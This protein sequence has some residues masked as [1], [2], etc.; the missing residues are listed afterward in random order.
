M[1]AYD[2]FFFKFGWEPENY[3]AQWKK[4]L[5]PLGATQ[6]VLILPPCLNTAFQCQVA[7][8]TLVLIWEC[9]FEVDVRLAS[10][11]GPGW[12]GQSGGS[13]GVVCGGGW[14]EEGGL[15]EPGTAGGR[16]VGGS[17]GGGG[18]VGRGGGN[19]GRRRVLVVVRRGHAPVLGSPVGC[20]SHCRPYYP[21]AGQTDGH[22]I[23]KAGYR[24][25]GLRSTTGSS[26]A[27]GSASSDLRSACRQG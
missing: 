20:I 4:P 9:A 25:G 21:P 22:T 2:D 6:P 3:S 13:H 7:A 14:R 8:G 27:S 16:W 18:G 11:E 15:G 19:A 23:S 1:H 26:R 24:R 5:S 12:G 17:R 10:P